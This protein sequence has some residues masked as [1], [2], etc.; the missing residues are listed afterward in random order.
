MNYGPAMIGPPLYPSNHHPSSFQNSSTVAPPIHQAQ[1]RNDVSDRAKT[2]NIM[3]DRVNRL[4][5]E[6]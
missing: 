4:K 5:G 6:A 2:Y 1:G 3:L